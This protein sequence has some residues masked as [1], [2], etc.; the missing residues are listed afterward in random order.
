MIAIGKY[1]DLRISREADPGLYLT[2]GD[3]HEV[4]LPR[5]YVTDSMAPGQEIRVFVYT[6]GEDRPV[7]T[8]DT[9]YATVGEFAFLQVRDVNRT[10]AFLDWGV[11][12]DLLVPYSEQKVHMA[13]G[14]I[15]PVY[16]YLDD[17]TKRPV[18]SARL[19][20]FLGNLPAD[21]RPGTR[22]SALVISHGEI[23]YR[24]IVDNLHWGMIYDNELRRPLEIGQT[25]EARVKYVRPDGKIDLSAGPAAVDR[26]GAACKRI[27][28][29]LDRAPQHTLMLSDNSD[30]A[31]I[32]AALGCSKKDFKK[33][34]GH[35]YK[36]GRIL[37]GEDRIVRLSD[38]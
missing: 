28:D 16:V 2:D 8:T 34:I 19:E 20:R 6:D 27:L 22:V 38:K 12:K 21:Y 13:V 17:V 31:D 14:G 25:V 33:A 30:P 4:L 5:R 9:P 1:N 37:L 32:R 29:A 23:G 10:G 24:V 3:G 11:M 35:L 18:A 7:A 15:Y 26:M 36:E